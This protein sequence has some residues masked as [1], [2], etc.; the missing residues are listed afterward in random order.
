LGQGFTL[1]NHFVSLSVELSDTI[2]GNVTRSAIKQAELTRQQALLERLQLRESV[3]SQLASAITTLNSSYKTATAATRRA[4]AEK[5]KF[6]AEVER[7]RSGRSDTA[8]VILF[9]GDLFTAE[10][11]AA[12]R[13]V[14]LR[15]ATHQLAL[16]RG[17]L[18]PALKPENP[19]M[20][21]P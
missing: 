20:A 7:Y 16:A 9:E 13:Q 1:N 14:L 21:K 4:R 17:T 19:E 2:T 11:Q 15:L 3:K 6:N 10:L 12:V 8:T 5:N 18:L